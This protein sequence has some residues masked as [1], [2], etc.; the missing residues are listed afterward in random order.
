MSRKSSLAFFLFCASALVLF[1]DDAPGGAP[2]TPPKQQLSEMEALRLQVAAQ[3]RQIDQLIVALQTLAKRLDVA[4]PAV[5]VDGKPTAEIASLNPVLPSAMLATATAATTSSAP[6]SQALA[7]GASSSSTADGAKLGELGKKVEGLERMLGGFK[8]SGDFRYR[9]D[10]QARTG[11]NIAGPLQNVRARYRLRLNVDKEIIP[12]LT[13]HTQLS[14]SPYSNET[15]NDQDFAGTA[16]KAPFSVAETWLQYRRKNFTI[17]GGRMEEVFSDNGGL[18]NNRFMWD[19]DVRFNGFDARYRVNN[20][21][22][23]RMGEY[24]LTNPNTPIVAAGSPFLAAG[25]RVGEK[26]RDATLT[27]PGVILTAKGSGWTHTLVG[28]YAV[29]RN[30]NQ[31]ALASTAAGYPVLVSNA[32]GITLSGAVGQT[33]NALTTPGGAIYA[34]DHFRIFRG[35]YRAEYGDFKIGNRAMPFYV[36]LNGSSNTGASSERGAYMFTANLGATRKAGDMR[37]LY[38]YARKEASSMISQYTDDDLGTGVGV[39]IYVNAFR[40][41]LGLTKFLALQNL[42]FFEKPLEAN[43]PGFA[44]PLQKGAN[45][46]FRYLGHLAFTF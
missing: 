37:F 39:N 44:V 35:A 24:I 33:G 19:D 18:G 8:F 2:A 27:D 45:Q 20:Y 12:G 22:E 40:F 14:T 3:Q 30:A 21:I 4:A 41:D 32:V 13:F 25:Y 1:G 34:A 5:G 17:R 42:F 11:N 16:V 26:L 43:R 15:T 38:Q 28:N 7:T 36:D 23:F 46:T 9:I 31:I 10:I 6:A 29:Y